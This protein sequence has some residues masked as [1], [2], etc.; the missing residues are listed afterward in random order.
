ML[1]VAQ[2][3]QIQQHTQKWICCFSCPTK[4][5]LYSICPMCA[6]VQIE[7]LLSHLLWCCPITWP[8][9]EV[10]AFQNRAH[11]CWTFKSAPLC[12]VTYTQAGH[13]LVCLGEG[14]FSGNSPGRCFVWKNTYT[15]KDMYMYSSS[16]LKYV[17][18]ER[19]HTHKYIQHLLCLQM[20]VCL[21]LSFPYCF[22][23]S[24]SSLSLNRVLFNWNL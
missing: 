12:P 18:H 23:Q 8:N 9:V 13:R 1:W 2:K 19:I 11:S 22:P 24:S 14:H 21:L 6:Y 15:H 16:Y 10:T 20:G 5:L 17:F 7:I 3:T 4:A